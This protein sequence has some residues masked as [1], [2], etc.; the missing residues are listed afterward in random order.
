MSV[1]EQ[2][3][4][5]FAVAEQDM[6]V[7]REAERL[8]ES[9]FEHGPTDV[10]V[11]D[12]VDVTL[13]DGL[14]Q[15][16]IKKGE[17]LPS[18]KPEGLSIEDRIG[19]FDNLIDTGIETI[20]AGHFGNP[21]DR[22]FGRA[23]VKHINSKSAEGDERYKKV[24]IQ[25]LVGAQKDGIVEAI[26]VLEGFDKERV[27]VH[28]YN[29]ISPE[30][31]ALAS[32]Q[33]NT[34]TKSA[35][36]LCD[37]TLIALQAGFQ[38]FSVS[39]EGAVDHTQDP[40]I[41]AEYHNHVTRFLFGHG[42]RSVNV[43]LANTFG[44]SPYGLWDT[45]GLADFNTTAKSVAEEFEDVTVTTSVHAHN[46]SGSA[47]EFSL[48][49]LH[50]GFDKVEGSIIGMGER[51]GNTAIVDVLE[52]LAEMATI[53]YENIERFVREGNI[54]EDIFATRA[55]KKSIFRDRYVSSHMA[56]SLPTMYGA[57]KSVGEIAETQRFN[58]TSIGKTRSYDAGSGPHG[59]ANAKYVESPM[60]HR[61]LE[62]YGHIA[63]IHALF[64]NPY[65]QA[66]VDVDIE[67][68]KAVTVDNHAGGGNT[69]KVHEGR[70]Q[71]APEEEVDAHIAVVDAR[72]AVILALMSHDMAFAV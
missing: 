19:I 8:I 57:A 16:D 2:D 12:I 35:Q 31:L 14:Q 17:I 64:G 11:I 4:D 47:T 62:I 60:R 6:A 65:A 10:R 39:G 45:E 15:D 70:L 52:R 63:S 55:L 40:N 7:N 3:I 69:R 41:V 24:K 67:G 68:M 27:I 59:E 33:P 48:D 43:N 38:H 26:K 22:P 30:L 29:R 34:P 32:I 61:L 21:E 56:F 49:A 54:P 72:H 9:A 37:T 58:E 71:R 25:M 66:I 42:A 46:D 5:V 1:I 18:G 20:E 51:A 44:S 53:D 28:V 36:D 13:R 50:A 23:L